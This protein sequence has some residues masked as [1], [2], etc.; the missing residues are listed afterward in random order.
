[1]ASVRAEEARLLR[2]KEEAE[3]RAAEITAELRQSQYADDERLAGVTDIE[4]FSVGVR[5][6]TTSESDGDFLDAGDESDDEEENDV[7]EVD[8]HDD[9]RGARAI[10]GKK[11]RQ[12]G[13]EFRKQLEGSTA[14]PRN[15][16]V[17][18]GKRVLST[19]SEPT[20]KKPKSSRSVALK[21]GGIT[22]DL[23]SRARESQSSQGEEGFGLSGLPTDEERE[24][25]DQEA[26]APAIVRSGQSK[27]ATKTK[28][29]NIE[30]TDI[31]VEVKDVHDGKKKSG[32]RGKSDLARGKRYGNQH[33]LLSPDDLQTYQTVFLST[34][35][36]FISTQKD[37]WSLR[38]SKP[39]V[40]CL[41]R[42]A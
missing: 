25:V 4:D 32:R 41:P 1:M 15:Q 6:P 38:T 37:T 40:E 18:T 19:A 8:D 9:F 35:I 17:R 30:E 22:K 20:S 29:R 11:R 23:Q 10:P 27:S 24:G 33:L 13:R 21:S 34:F 31:V 16:E 14:A 39:F 7:I 2:E 36:S 26:Q 42:V 3:R 12:R 28:T 5:A